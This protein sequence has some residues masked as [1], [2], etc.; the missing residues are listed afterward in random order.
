MAI[1]REQ[2]AD[3]VETLEGEWTEIGARGLKEI[4]RSADMYSDGEVEHMKIYDRNLTG[5]A[6]SDASRPPEAHKTDHNRE[7][8]SSGQGT[9]DRVEISGGLGA[10]ARAVST[11][12]SA[13]ANRIQALAAQV[14]QGTY[15]PDSLR[16]SRGMIAEAVAV[17]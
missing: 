7:V 17:R 11:D 9:G 16:T 14:Q 2:S 10:L 12:Q 1:P 15:Q 13:R 4:A 6:A 3:L 8:G 5:T